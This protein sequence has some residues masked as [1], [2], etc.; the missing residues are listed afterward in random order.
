MTKAIPRR[1]KRALE[2]AID[3]AEDLDAIEALL[4]KQRT[5]VN[6]D[7]EYAFVTTTKMSEINDI[8]DE[9]SREAVFVA[10]AKKAA[11]DMLPKLKQLGIPTE[12]PVTYKG[13]RVK[14]DKHMAKIRD[15]LRAKKDTVEKAERV[16]KLRDLK[17]MGK[18]IQQEVLKKRSKEKKDFL[19]KVKKRPV[20]ELFED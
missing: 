8:N 7:L 19:D 12:V 5:K 9:F 16:K 3:L 13:E 15:T 2:P 1:L 14:D 20:S 17:K 4:R 11:E 18:K 6:P 10:Q